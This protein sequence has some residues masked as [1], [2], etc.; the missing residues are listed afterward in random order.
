MLVAALGD[1]HLGKTYLNRTTEAG[2]NQR[3]VDFEHSFEAALQ[4]ALELGPDLVIWLGDIFDHPRPS[5]RSYRVAQR[6]L[7]AIRQHG[8]PAV[9]ISGNHDTPRLPGR[10]SPYS[11]LADAFPEMRFACRMSYERFDFAGLAVH[12]VPQMLQAQDAKEALGQ[13]AANRKADVTNL[14][15]THPRLVQVPP[16]YSDINEIE[17]DA[18]ELR[19]DLVLLG[20]YHSFCEVRSGM[21]YAGATDSFTFSDNPELPKGFVLLD[22]D[23]GKCRHVP[24]G[25]RRQLTTLDTIYAGGLGPKE[26][27]ERLCAAAASVPEGAVARIYVEQVEPETWSLVDLQAVYAASA[28]L[29]LQTLPQFVATTANAE[30]P[31]T[32]GL[33]EQWE[34]YVSQ[35]D[36]TGFE[37]QRVVSLGRDYLEKAVSSK[38]RA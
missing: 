32:A 24:L 36:L 35:Q 21:W 13:A 2:V 19:A 29:S 1:A 26:L 30:L 28:G 14:L 33:P 7:Q 17:V 10:G 8:I 11:P 20:H 34:G 31:S 38:E 37:R 27:Q 15:I 4:A 25:G 5:Y 22:T 18:S 16:R 9:I 23:T 3:E 12:A 6:A